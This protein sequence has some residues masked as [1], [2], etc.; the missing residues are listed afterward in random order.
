MLEKSAFVI[1]NQR[2]VRVQEMIKV[3][4]FVGLFNANL[5]FGGFCMMVFKHFFP[6]KNRNKLQN[7][8]LVFL[9]K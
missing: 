2:E 7:A 4:T 1:I 6:I 5:F 3:Q 8:T 9:N